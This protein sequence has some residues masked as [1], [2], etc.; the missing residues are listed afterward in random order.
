MWP[1]YV[2]LLDSWLEWKSSSS[3]LR[4]FLWNWKKKTLTECF[5]LLKEVYG[6]NVMSHTRVFE[7]HRWIMEGLGESGRW[8]MSGTPFN[9]KNQRICWENQWNCWPEGQTVNQK[10]YLEVLTMLQEWVR[11]KRPELW[12]KKSWILHQDNAPAHNA[13]RVKHFLANKCIPVLKHPPFHQI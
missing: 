8:W 12:K 7:W 13:L 10:Y 2:V 5:Q 1:Y 3:S 4:N 6:D 11:Q 9:I